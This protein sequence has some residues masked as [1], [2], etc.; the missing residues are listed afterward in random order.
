MITQAF[1]ASQDAAP[2]GHQNRLRLFLILFILNVKQGEVSKSDP[3]EI[4]FL[5]TLTSG[6]FLNQKNN[7]QTSHELLQNLASICI[8]F[9]ASSRKRQL[10]ASQRLYTILRQFQ[11]SVNK[12]Q[13]AA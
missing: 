2:E 3:S 6:A 13:N 11:L 7:K 4:G 8:S 5:M 9:C 10:K 12:F 1:H